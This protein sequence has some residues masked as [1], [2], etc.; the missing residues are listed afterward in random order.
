MPYIDPEKAK[1]RRKAYYAAHREKAIAD[2]ATWR[3]NPENKKIR[4]TTERERGKIRF[5]TDPAFRE[6]RRQKS[7]ESYAKFQGLR[8]AL[9]EKHLGTIAEQARQILR[10][11]IRRGEITRS[12]ICSKCHSSTPPIQAHHPDYSK[13]LSVSWLCVFCHADE[14]SITASS[15]LIS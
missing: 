12:K 7:R 8:L 6:Y 9:R 2:V 15:A 4:N 1:A 13:P 11:A 3:E 14:H 5:R 10:N